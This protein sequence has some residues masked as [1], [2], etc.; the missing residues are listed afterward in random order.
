MVKR[1]L[2][3]KRQTNDGLLLERFFDQNGRM[4][5]YI[6]KLD[7][8]LMALNDNN[9]LHSSQFTNALKT[10]SEAIKTMATASQAT[11]KIFRNVLY[12]LVLALIVLAGVE[13]LPTVKGLF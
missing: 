10:N 11:G 1:A 6:A 12:L 7:K 3:N 9:V 2:K 5:E 8:T 13:K 4:I